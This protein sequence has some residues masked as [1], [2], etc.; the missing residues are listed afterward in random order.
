VRLAA[1]LVLSGCVGP[2]E[3]LLAVRFPPD[4]DPLE[5]ADRVELVVRTDRG[6]SVHSLDPTAQRLEFAIS[7]PDV[8]IHQ[9]EVSA[10]FGPDRTAYGRGGPYLPRRDAHPAPIYF[11]RIRLFASTPEP[12]PSGGGF[13]TPTPT[14]AWVATCEGLARYDH[15]TGEF[16]DGPALDGADRARFAALDDGRIVAFVGTDALVLDEDSESFA[17]AGTGLPDSTGATV[18]SFPGGVVVAGPDRLWVWSPDAPDAVAIDETL[19]PPRTGASVTVLAGDVPRALV[20]GGVDTSGFPVD[21][22]IVVDLDPPAVGARS[23]LAIARSAHAAIEV[24]EL[25]RNV[26]IFGGDAATTPTDS[27][28]DVI[29]DASAQPSVRVPAPEALFRAR[30]GTAAIGL[31]GG[32]VLLAGGTTDPMS[33]AALAERFRIKGGGSVVLTD[34]LPEPIPHPAAVRLADGA[35]LVTGDGAAALYVAD[36]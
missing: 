27:V 32:D 24:P 12:P 11:A 28:E 22:V 35:I 10:F 18:A 13:A 31:P 7:D 20:A 4:Q 21:E 33:D 5:G 30:S 34:P 29:V 9:I 26:W 23:H 25:R 19:A 14:G 16:S 3:W 15:A 8:L 2:T 36:P 17:L 1:V 6:E